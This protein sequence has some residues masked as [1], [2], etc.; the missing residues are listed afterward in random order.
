M[1]NLP[2]LLGAPRR[3]VLAGLTL[4]LLGQA[5]G[6][7]AAG[8]LVARSV[9][10]LTGRE[11][12]PTAVLMA[13]VVIATL[14]A[15]G[16]AVLARRTAEA[17]AQ[18]YMTQIRR[19]LFHQAS[20]LGYRRLRQQPR[21]LLMLR[22]VGD[23]GAV[24]R[25]VGDGVARAISGVV[26]ATVVLLALG[27]LYAPAA[28]VGGAATAAS[29]LALVAARAWL[30]RRHAAVRRERARLAVALGEAMADA[31]TVRAL[32]D[33]ARML[34]RLDRASEQLRAQSLARETASALVRAWPLLIG[35]LATIAL[36]IVARTDLAA[37]AVSLGQL[38][39]ALLLLGLLGQPLADM[40]QVFDLHAEF[41]VA[42][43]RLTAFLDRAQRLPSSRGRAALGEGAGQLTLEQARATSAMP[44]LSLGMAMGE[45]LCL[46]GPSGRGKSALLR[47]I[48]GLDAGVS[49]SVR[50]DG[51][52]I[53]TLDA[54]QRAGGIRLATPDLPLQRGTVRALFP[55]RTAL[56]DLARAGELS[57][58]GA[59]FGRLPHGLKT[60]LAEGGAGMPSGL[61]AQLLLA[62]ALVTR[63][64]VL[65]ID[66]LDG[67][68]DADGLSAIRGLLVRREMVIVIATRLD[69]LKNACDRLIHLGETATA[70]R[71]R[72]RTVQPDSAH[73]EASA[74]LPW[75]P[76]S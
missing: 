57:G 4:A 32:G 18:D 11:I 36:L 55:R 2:P 70:V 30:T 41:Q 33:P 62:R 56:R 34:R 48:A 59:D 16:C 6:T 71:L 1:A 53:D 67:M 51:V 22:F 52:D 60:R 65:L 9:D 26:L 17:L 13:G 35:A 66:G 21:A 50:L 61:Q 39:G 25:W 37:G 38:A 69:S 5:A 14:A 47:W 54:R 68:L 15:L 24:G 12:V 29:G 23:L 7:A 76:R 64:K 20:R 58:L 75:N 31:V 72:L 63:P 49:G 74:C 44:P 19:A 73:R 43:A 46:D 10:Q 40:A 27:L 45:S 28:L 42:R 3:P 8:L